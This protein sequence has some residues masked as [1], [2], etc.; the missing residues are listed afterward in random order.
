[1]LRPGALLDLRVGGADDGLDLIRVDETGDVGVGDLRRREADDPDVSVMIYHAQQR[2]YSHVVLL[3]GGCLVEGTE[4]L[5]QEA[6]RTLSPDDET[7][8]VA[9]GRELEKVEAADVDELNTGEVAERLDDALVLVVDDKRATALAV[10]AVPELARARAELAGVGHLDN[11]RVRLEALEESDSLL[12]L[13]ERLSLAGDD[14][15]DLLDLLDAVATGQDERR[16]SGRSKGGDD[17]EAALVLVD[18]DVPLAPGLGGGEHATATAHV[19]E[20]SL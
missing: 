17:S 1:M 20:G 10:T 14:E 13:G 18:L 5:I 2:F 19:T 16:E 4:D 8:K 12:G 9:T 11:V 3:E 15:G 6:E 7:A